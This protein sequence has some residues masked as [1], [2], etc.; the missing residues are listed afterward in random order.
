MR[1]QKGRKVDRDVSRS[2]TGSSAMQKG[3]SAGWAQRASRRSLT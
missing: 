2:K 1:S 3:H